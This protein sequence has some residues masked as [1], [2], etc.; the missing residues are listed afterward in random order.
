MNK[1][2]PQRFI[3][4]Q[5]CEELDAM[6]ALRI[7]SEMPRRRS[8]PFNLNAGPSKGCSPMSDAA[9]SFKTLGLSEGQAPVSLKEN[10]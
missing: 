5:K 3:T 10:P 6:I 8:T 4:W 7:G 2:S 9:T 1:P